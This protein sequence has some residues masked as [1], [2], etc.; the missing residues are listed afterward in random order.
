MNVVDHNQDTALG[1]D[2]TEQF[3]GGQRDEVDIGR[4]GGSHPE[5]RLQGIALTRTQRGE[6][7]TTRPEQLLKGCLREM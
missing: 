2:L 5:C 3:H 4:I 1:A 7:M 6:S